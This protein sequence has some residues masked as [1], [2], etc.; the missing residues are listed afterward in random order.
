MLVAGLEQMIVDEIDLLLDQA[1]EVLIDPAAAQLLR[2]AMEDRDIVGAGKTGY[3]PIVLVPMH[4]PENKPP[5]AD[6][7]DERILET[8]TLGRLRAR[9]K[10]LKAEGRAPAEK[11]R[12]GGFLEELSIAI[13][14]ISRGGQAD[15]RHRRLQHIGQ[16]REHGLGEHGHPAPRQKDSEERDSGDPGKNELFF[17]IHM[18]LI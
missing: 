2:K 11:I 8:I 1:H 9:Q 6:T 18:G 10:P 15:S 16:R 17:F 13:E 7:F 14:E 3:G 4:F 12:I 5:R